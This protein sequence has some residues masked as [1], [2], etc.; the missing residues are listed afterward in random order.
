[1]PYLTRSHRN[2]HSTNI[3]VN[4]RKSINTKLGKYRLLADGGIY[5]NELNKVVG[6]V[7]KTAEIEEGWRMRGRSL[8]EFL[9][10]YL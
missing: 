5:D 9:M 1:M 2:G 3:K 6:Y 7:T 10:K 8:Q 4:P